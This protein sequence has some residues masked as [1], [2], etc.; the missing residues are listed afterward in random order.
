M[1]QKLVIEGINYFDIWRLA[2][3]P[4]ALP[5]QGRNH[6]TK[7]ILETPFYLIAR[8]IV[9]RVLYGVPGKG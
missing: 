9:S 6:V 3:G 2:L 7:E 4:G 1:L 8:D 5:L